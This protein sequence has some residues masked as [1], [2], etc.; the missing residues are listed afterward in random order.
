MCMIQIH[1]VHYNSDRYP[2]VATAA[3][4]GDPE[5]IAVLAVFADVSSHI[6]TKLAIL[7][8]KSRAN[9]LIFCTVV[10]KV[11]EHDCV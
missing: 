11:F 2:D 4:S 9:G 5:A 1:F 6:I 10:R 7:K 8:E 3:A